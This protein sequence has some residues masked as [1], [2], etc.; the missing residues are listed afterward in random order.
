MENMSEQDRAA[1]AQ[2]WSGTTTPYSQIKEGFTMESGQYDFVVGKLTPDFDKSG[3][4]CIVGEFPITSPA[5]FAQPYKRTLYVGT[6][7]DPKAQL[8][9]TRLVS[10]GLRFLRAIATANR[11]PTN[12]QSDAALCAAI[13]NRAFGCRIEET[14][15]VQNGVEKT[16]SDFG[17][18][19]TPSGL[20]PARLDKSPASASTAKPMTNGAATGAVFASE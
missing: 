9:D 8:P 4:Y 12:D 20:I 7:K 15:Y 17:R 18:N 1:L 2:A 11:V 6:K 13:T 19:V 10:P 14:K 5:G 16:G 3:M